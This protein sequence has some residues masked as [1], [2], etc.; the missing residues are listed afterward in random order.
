[1]SSEGLVNE[2][3]DVSKNQKPPA[4]APKVN[5]E[6][7]GEIISSVFEAKKTLKPDE[8]KLINKVYYGDL[9]EEQQGSRGYEETIWTTQKQFLE[10]H[11][12]DPPIAQD[13]KTYL[14]CGTNGV[15]CFALQG[16]SDRV[17]SYLEA[18]SGLEKQ[19]FKQELGHRF[20]HMETQG[21]GHEFKKLLEVFMKKEPQYLSLFKH[22]LN[23]VTK[24]IESLP[25]GKETYGTKVHITE[26]VFPVV[27]TLEHTLLEPN[28][29]RD[30][31][32]G[33]KGDEYTLYYCNTTKTKKGSGWTKAKMSP[34]IVTSETVPSVAFNETHCA[35]LYQPHDELDKSVV[36]ISL[37]RLNEHPAQKEC[38]RFCFQFPKDHFSD[39][40]I[41]KI[42]INKAGI[43]TV[44]FA[45]GV[46][47]IDSTREIAPKIV[48][49]E[50]RLVTATTS[51]EK[52]LLII[53]TDAGECIG[54]SWRTGDI[55]FSELT[56]V[57]EPIYSLLYSNKRVFMHTACA[58]SGRLNPYLSEAMT[59]LPC[60]RITGMDACGTLIFAAEKHGSIQIFS[61]VARCILFPFKP[62]KQPISPSSLPRYSSIKASTDR[63]VVL[64]EN[65]LIRCYNISKEGF[66]RIEEQLLKKKNKK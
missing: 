44:S 52:D 33:F 49:L 26:R 57:V 39:Q 22:Y 19:S 43:I 46:V 65:G 37:F 42:E 9:R 11:Y 54:V 31:S 23:K 59:H 60:A 61:T 36:T 5:I 3:L 21:D 55:L 41:L 45:N 1:M 38:D 15:F 27:T 28:K 29:E 2:F 56:P 63:L 51:H 8:K 66:K 20:I 48:L 18:L 25:E 7:T 58:V 35:V 53:G 30:S 62:P 12:I 16:P 64:Y 10:Q 34:F 47:I 32:S 17:A 50:K 13:N 40:G 4:E 24:K 14:M 6:S